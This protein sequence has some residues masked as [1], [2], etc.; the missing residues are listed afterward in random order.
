MRGKREVGQQS[1]LGNWRKEDRLSADPTPPPPPS[2]GPAP[3][4]LASTLGGLAGT[5]AG[6]PPSHD[7]ASGSV[8]KYKGKQL[9]FGY[10]RS[11]KQYHA[12]TAFR[13]SAL[14]PSLLVVSLDL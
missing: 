7:S 11:K 2:G 10:F 12:L 14:C 4:A 8:R 3:V 1:S 6:C 13:T 9:V 5:E